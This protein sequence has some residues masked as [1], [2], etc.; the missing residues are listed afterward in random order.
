MNEQGLVP[1][2][3]DSLDASVASLCVAVAGFFQLA[4]S[5]FMRA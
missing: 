3:G 1:K 5:R 2:I 4:R